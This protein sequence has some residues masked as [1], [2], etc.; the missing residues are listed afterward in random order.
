MEVLGSSKTKAVNKNL[1]TLMVTLTE[2]K[3]GNRLDGF[4]FY[5]LGVV[6]KVCVVGGY[7][8]IYVCIYMLRMRKR[9]C[10]S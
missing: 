1:A 10:A 3:R 6:L 8:Y 5:L 9:T 2:L 7:I 4:G